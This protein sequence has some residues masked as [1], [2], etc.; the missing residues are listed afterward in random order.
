MESIVIVLNFGGP[1]NTDE[2]QTFLF[3][4]LR[5]PNTIQLPVPGWLQDVF[6]HWIA[7]RRA[8]ETARQYGEIGGRST[9]VEDTHRIA[10]ALEAAL[11]KSGCRIPVMEA[12]RYVPGHTREVVARIMASADAAHGGQEGKSTPPK[13][14]LAV[15]L[16]PHFS[17]AST[18]SSL[19]Q[20]RGELH[21]AGYTGDLRALRS[22][23]DDPGYLDAVADRLQACLDESG[24]RTGETVILCSAHGLPAAYVKNGDPYRLELYRTVERLAERFAAWRFELSFQS[25][26]GPRAWL[27]PYTEHIIPELAAQ[28]AKDVVFLPLSFVSD[29]I[30]TLYEIDRTYFD[31]ARQCGLRPHRMVAIGDHP[32]HV[33]TLR[34]AVLRWHAGRGGVPVEELLPPDQSHA[35]WRRYIWGAGWAT[36]FAAL[37]YA[38]RG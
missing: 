11:A 24:L 9:I 28:G 20:L 17:Y 21:R 27:T 16:Y 19:E 5:D 30:E 33:R 37:L 36:L 34:D 23:P 38:L 14:I 35:R 32:A 8:P 4:I 6:A 1:R 18:G 26:I 22:Y 13:S 29:H 2:V 12:Q 31:L 25:R 15:P 7:A 10:R 3:E